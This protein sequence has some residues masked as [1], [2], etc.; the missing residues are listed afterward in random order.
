MKY[1]YFLGKIRRI[2]SI[3]HLLK[4]SVIKTINPGPAEL[5]SALFIIKCVNLYQ[6]LGSNNLIG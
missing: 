5:G 1:L 4:Y 2:S 3:S 6:E